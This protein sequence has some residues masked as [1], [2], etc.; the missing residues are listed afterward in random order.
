MKIITDVDELRKPNEKI[1]LYE[2]KSV[3]EKLEI[4]L[5]ESNT[6]GLGLA[7]PQIGV[8]KKVAIIRINNDNFQTNLDLVN[9]EIIEYRNSFTHFNEGCLSL[10]GTNVNTTRF[11]EIFVKDDLHPAGFVATGLIAVAVQ[12]E[13]DHI[14]NILITDRSIQKKKIGRNDPCPCGKIID[15]KPVKYKKCHGG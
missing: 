10:P 4:S 15:G 6:P 2:A 9:P 8:H 14:N 3:I 1:D 5:K 12:H 7:A 13:V 11:K